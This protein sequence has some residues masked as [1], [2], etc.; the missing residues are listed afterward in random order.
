MTTPSTPT[1]TT[2][3]PST[4]PGATGTRSVSRVVTGLVEGVK[5]STTVLG[6]VSR[7]GWVVLGA[8]VLALVVG[9]RFGWLEPIVVAGGLLTLVVGLEK[10]VPRGEWI[11]RAAGVGLIAWGAVR[12][13]A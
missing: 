4:I 9:Q 11:G 5:R 1:A 12:L 13:L 8:G 10:L 2:S 6:W 3:T 7:A